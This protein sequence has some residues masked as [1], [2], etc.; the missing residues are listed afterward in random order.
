MNG[1]AAKK[2]RK[3]VFGDFSL[4]DTKYMRDLKGV[5]RCIGKR[6]T[7]QDAKRRPD[8]SI[9]HRDAKHRRIPRWLKSEKTRN[10]I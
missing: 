10:I 8:L 5:I 3:S 9:I 7:Y 1:K 4:R 2:L 6:R